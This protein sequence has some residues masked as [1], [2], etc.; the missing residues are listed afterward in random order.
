[1]SPSAPMCRGLRIAPP[2]YDLPTRGGGGWLGMAK[3]PLA[4]PSAFNLAPKN[5]SWSP[6]ARREETR[7]SRNELFQAVKDLVSDETS[8]NQM[9]TPFGHRRRNTSRGCGPTRTR[10]KFR[11]IL[12]DHRRRDDE[13]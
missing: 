12:V 7:A 2:V 10:Q 4:P 13:H 5:S 6:A 8:T 1:M 3:A 9:L 11:C